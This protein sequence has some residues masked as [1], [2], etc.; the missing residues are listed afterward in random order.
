MLTVGSTEWNYSILFQYGTHTH[1]HTIP[2]HMVTRNHTLFP[3]VSS[4]QQVRLVQPT[5]ATG[6][7]EPQLS[8][9][10]NSHSPMGSTVVSENLLYRWVSEMVL[11]ITLHLFAFHCRPQFIALS[12]R[13]W[14]LYLREPMSLAV[15]KGLCHPRAPPC[16]SSLL[17][18]EK[19]SGFPSTVTA[20]IQE[21]T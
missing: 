7:A 2:L 8:V 16:S 9:A 14:Y 18:A 17:A 10:I 6:M 1:I 11:I 4:P 15:R 12:V 3:A 5:F 21:I 20:P 13:P 19:H